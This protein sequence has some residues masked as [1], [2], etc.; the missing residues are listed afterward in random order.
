MMK[1]RFKLVDTDGQETWT[2]QL[3][4]DKLPGVVIY[5]AKAYRLHKDHGEH[6][7]YNEVDVMFL[8]PKKTLVI[9]LGQGG[10][11]APKY[12]PILVGMEVG[13]IRI[14]PSRLNPK[15]SGIYMASYRMNMKIR[16]QQISTG[17]RVERLA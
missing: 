7:T 9:G 5:K 6:H 11:T 10:P 15:S 13:E 3:W 16:V 17:L 1:R 14:V 8:E 4:S 12:V 2:Q